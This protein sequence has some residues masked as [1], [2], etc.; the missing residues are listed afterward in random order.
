MLFSATLTYAVLELAYEHMNDPVHVSASAE[1][2]T[3]DKIEHVIYHVGNREKPSLLLGLLGCETDSRVL[4]FAN[5]RRTAQRLGEVLQANGID[6]APITGDMEQR[7]RL[8]VLE[9][10]KAGDLPVLVATDVAS[11]GLHIDAVTHVINYDLPQDPEDYVHRS[12]RTA[13]AGATGKALSLV[14]ENDV[15]SLEPIEQLIGFKLDFVI[16]D[17]SMFAPVVRA[18]RKRRREEGPHSRVRSGRADQEPR[19]RPRDPKPQRSQA[20]KAA[21]TDGSSKAPP[22]RRRRRRRP[23]PTSAPSRTA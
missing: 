15:D 10:F 5:M 14:S 3:A 4:I 19:R 11:R 7:Q 6:A 20:H 13:R 17:D 21:A 2:L 22:R 12:G 23:G 9:R 8:R 18:A 1:Q 16:P